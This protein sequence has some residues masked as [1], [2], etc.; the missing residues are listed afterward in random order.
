MH[1]DKREER[2]KATAGEI[3]AAVGLKETKTGHTLCDPSNPIVL[4]QM[5]F[6]NLLY[7]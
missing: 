2:K 5:D 4:E 7:L 1:A 6:Q 3:A